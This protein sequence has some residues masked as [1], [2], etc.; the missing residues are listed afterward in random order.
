MKRRDVLTVLGGLT[1]AP[2]LAS[3]QIL[4]LAP[5]PIVPGPGDVVVTLET[6]L[7]PIVIA[8][9]VR[10]A[11]LTTANFLRY[12]DDKRYDG[13]SFWRSAKANSPVDYGLIE[14][15]LQ[16]DARKLLP[17]VAHEPTSQ[18]GLRHVDGTV[19]LA[20]TAPGTGDSDFFICVGE[21]PYLDANPAGEGDNLGFA[22]FGQV[23]KGMEVV[24]KILNLPTPGVA[25]NPV[26]KG[27]ILDPPVPIS[28][29]RRV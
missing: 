14:G 17:P 4:N 27:Q 18:T 6:G 3:A 26:M 9:K 7:G 20:R 5:A 29:A 25:T 2:G 1:A 24:H 21:A 23:I 16:G 12:V 11:P 28:S 15:G 19:S 10:Q 22:A 8:L 13:A